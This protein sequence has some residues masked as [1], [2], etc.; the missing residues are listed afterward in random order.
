M[1][2]FVR[3]YF[4]TQVN[5]FISNYVYIMY[6]PIVIILDTSNTCYKYSVSILLV[7]Y[8]ISNYLHK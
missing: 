1:G 5:K 7:F 4:K 3:L 6:I 8:V 2:N